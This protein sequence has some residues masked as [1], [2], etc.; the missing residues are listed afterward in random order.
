MTSGWRW[1]IAFEP[2]GD[3]VLAWVSERHPVAEW[4]ELTVMHNPD[5]AGNSMP[6]EALDALAYDLAV[7]RKLVEMA[8]GVRTGELRD[9]RLIRLISV[10]RTYGEDLDGQTER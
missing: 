6:R 2:H 10:L 3:P 4:Y 7:L 9:P 8:D 1:Q 5:E